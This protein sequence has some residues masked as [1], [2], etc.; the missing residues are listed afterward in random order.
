MR[1]IAV[2]FFAVLAISCGKHEILSPTDNASAE[3]KF[4]NES[5]YSVSI[6]NTSFSGPIIVDKLAPGHS[7]SVMVYPSNNHGVGSVFPIRYWYRIEGSDTWTGG[8]NP[9]PNAQITRNIEA[10]KSYVIYIPQPAKLVGASSYLRMKN[11][12]DMSI[13]FNRLSI[14]Y[15]QMNG[16]VPIPSGYTGI[17]EI[18]HSPSGVEY[19]EYYTVYQGM[20]N[21]YKIPDF[22]AK[23]GY[24]YNFEFDGTRVIAGTIEETL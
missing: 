4:V 6:H 3:I 16:E 22:I 2:L 9:D 11:S 7:A 18:E 14:H 24:I 12:S 8:A 13:E 19:Y 5:R 15:K 20:A 23:T 17:Y 10:D 1:A 21:Y